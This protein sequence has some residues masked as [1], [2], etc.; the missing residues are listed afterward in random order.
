MV[1]SLSFSTVVEPL[2][3]VRGLPAPRRFQM[4]LDG[5]KTQ[6]R[7][8]T[9]YPWLVPEVST[10]LVLFPKGIR[11]LGWLICVWGLTY[12]V[13][14][15]QSCVT[16]YLLSKGILVASAFRDAAR[17]CRRGKDGERFSGV[18]LSSAPVDTPPHDTGVDQA[19][20][21]QVRPGWQS[22]AECM[23]CF[24]VYR[25]AT[26]GLLLPGARVE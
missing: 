22:L 26:C 15:V 20:R 25:C 9:V 11:L 5:S 13:T 7:L 14:C 24:R 19:L 2:L 12:F 4:L 8:S 6:C 3:H 16:M 10:A 1:S 18:H 17:V 23:V 21:V